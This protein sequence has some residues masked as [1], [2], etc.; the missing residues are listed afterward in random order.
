MQ[1]A[2]SLVFGLSAP[3]IVCSLLV[4]QLPSECN[5]RCSRKET[6]AYLFSLILCK[7]CLASLSHISSTSHMGFQR[8][9]S[10]LFSN[11]LPRNQL[12]LQG[13]EQSDVRAFTQASDGVKTPVHHHASLLTV[14]QEHWG[15]IDLKR[16]IDL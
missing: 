16:S 5:K 10:Y 4:W 2:L 9:H 3:V 14:A 13:N 8:L 11:R 15:N 12:R 6:S 1:R 7:H